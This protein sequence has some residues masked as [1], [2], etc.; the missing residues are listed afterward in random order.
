MDVSS[1][2]RK[3]G[4]GDERR[5]PRVR[6]TNPIRDLVVLPSVLRKLPHVERRCE[7][8]A[9]GARERTKADP[10][11]RKPRGRLRYPLETRVFGPELPYREAGASPGAATELVRV[12][13]REPRRYAGFLR[14]LSNHVEHRLL[15]EAPRLRAYVLDRRP[16][17]REVIACPIV[18]HRE[19]NRKPVAAVSDA[20]TSW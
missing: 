14:E 11:V 13:E 19:V 7:E 3:V 20:T 15:D 6:P 1:L 12:G 8:L 10:K 17:E 5:R 18:S 9:D 16:I 2:Q 4:E